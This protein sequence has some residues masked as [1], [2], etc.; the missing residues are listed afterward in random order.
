MGMSNASKINV[1][2]GKCDGKGKL[3]FYGHIDSGKCFACMG[4]G[5]VRVQSVSVRNAARFRASV[6][7]D[8]LTE[9]GDR[10]LTANAPW[11]LSM[12]RRAAADMLIVADTAWSRRML[13]TMPIGLRAAV[14]AAGREL[15]A[16]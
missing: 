16:A 4:A 9:C 1:A 5:T 10:I 13:A 14:I 6:A 8:S 3:W 12:A 11:A 2:C 7:L 15:K